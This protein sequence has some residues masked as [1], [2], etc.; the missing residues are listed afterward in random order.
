M[1]IHMKQHAIYFGSKWLG[2]ETFGD[3]IAT[4][5]V[6]CY[7]VTSGQIE[8]RENDARSGSIN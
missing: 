7:V 1:G 4:E 5:R 6:V 2:E 8:R 3:L